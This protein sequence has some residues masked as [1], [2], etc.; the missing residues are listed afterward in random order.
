MSRPDPSDHAEGASLRRHVLVGSTALTALVSGLVWWS[1]TTEIS[2][3]VIAP[4][5]VVVEGGIKLV[6]HPS[7]GVVSQILVD[8]GDG[9]AAGDLLVR[10]DDT[11][12]AASRNIVL[13]QLRDAFARLGRLQAEATGLT[14]PIAAGELSDEVEG[15]EFE[16]L[17]R[18]QGDLMVAR[19]SAQ[20]G[21]RDQLLRQIDQARSKI[22][23]LEARRSASEAQLSILEAERADLEALL[24]HGLVSGSRVNDIILR[25]HDLESTIAQSASGIDELTAMVAERRSALET[26]GDAMRAEVLS[27]QQTVRGEIARLLQQQLALDAQLRELDIRAP[28][29]GT[30]HASIVHTV[31]GVIGAGE[32]AMTIIPPQARAVIDMRISPMDI[33]AVTVA[34]EAMFRFPGLDP[35]KTPDLSAKIATISPDLSMDPNTGGQFYLARTV[36]A[37]SEIDRLPDH[38]VLVAG[39]PVEA[40]IKTSDRTVLDFLVHPFSDLVSRA[41]RED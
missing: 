20:E 17:V 3:A 37:Q 11:A 12:L 15:A 35:R 10:L 27:D 4:G 9:V 7:G 29:A 38:V 31:G 2:G 41:F 30:V 14:T 40:F 26:E 1:A 28:L 32:T 22:K 33:E 23:G 13:S 16:E 34:Q 5:T 21:R 8:N 39:M 24:A 25:Q 18:V 36:I 6:Q 19:A